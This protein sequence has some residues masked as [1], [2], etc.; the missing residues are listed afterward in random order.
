MVV[1]VLSLACSLDLTMSRAGHASESA[2]IGDWIAHVYGDDGVRAM[3]H[4]TSVEVFRVEEPEGN[5]AEDELIDGYAITD[6]VTINDAKEA[7]VIGALLLDAASYEKPPPGRPG[8]VHAVRK[9]GGFEP[10]LVF[11]FTDKKGRTSDAVVCFNCREIRSARVGYLSGQLF[12][13]EDTRN[14]LRKIASR[15]Y[16]HD[17]A[18]Q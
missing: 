9:C 16:P 18:F 1:I 8:K 2:P 17:P 10:G 15:Y 14:T 13:T 11:Q 12:F 5:E 4:P 3:K 6:I 7:S